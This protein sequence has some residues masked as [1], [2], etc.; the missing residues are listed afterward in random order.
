MLMAAALELSFF[1][2]EVWATF[3]EAGVNA[4]LGLGTFLYGL[5]VKEFTIEA[6]GVQR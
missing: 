1:L 2:R 3:I 5:W 6:F 4:G